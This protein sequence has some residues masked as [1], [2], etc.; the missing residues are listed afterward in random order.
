V[1]LGAT[2][3]LFRSIVLSALGAAFVAGGAPVRAAIASEV[4]APTAD[5]M[6]L[7]DPFKRPSANG[8]DEKTPRTELETIPADQ[9]KL[10]G[11][12][13][14]PMAIKAMLIAPNGKP[15][16]VVEGTKVGTRGGFVSKI[17]TTAV[18]VREKIVNPLG[19]EEDVE[20]E[21]PLPVEK[22]K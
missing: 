15:F 22:K 3:W 2:R 14:G 1:S 19:Q 11:V 6:K 8:A 12:V 13:T 20:T 4:D 5:M 7:R 16:Y 10:T 17:T 9:L 21:I 18:K